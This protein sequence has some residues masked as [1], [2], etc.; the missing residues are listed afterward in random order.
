MEAIVVPGHSRRGRVAHD[1]P[2][3]HFMQP[4]DVT[5]GPT[6]LLKVYNY[7]GI[8]AGQSAVGDI[9]KWWAETVCGGDDTLHAQLSAEAGALKE[10]A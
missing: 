2:L 3:P 5:C 9:L 8:E 4:D 7:Y 6:C 10:F 1:L